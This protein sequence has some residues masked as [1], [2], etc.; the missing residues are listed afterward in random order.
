ML[1]LGLISPYGVMVILGLFFSVFFFFV[2]I[3]VKTLKI[4]ITPYYGEIF[5]I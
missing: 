2:C 5:I 1:I 4:N 3:A